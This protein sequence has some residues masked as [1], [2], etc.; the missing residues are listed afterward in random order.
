MLLV[1][2]T[3]PP[4][5]TDAL[6]TANVAVAAVL[7]PTVTADSKPVPQAFVALPVNNVAVFTDT[8]AVPIACRPIPTPSTAALAD[9]S[10]ALHDRSTE[11]PEQACW[12]EAESCRVGGMH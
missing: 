10:D 5:V 1:N 12:L 6:L 11:P 9:G 4:L 3:E 8:A 7:T 2:V